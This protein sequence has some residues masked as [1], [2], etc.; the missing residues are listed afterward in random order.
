MKDYIV[1]DLETT[2]FS[3]ETCEIIEIGAWKVKEGVVVDK[4]CTL[5]RPLT[6]IPRDVQSIT[7]ITNE[8]VATCDTMEVILPEF[9]DFCEDLPFLGHNLPF[10][11]RFLEYRGKFIGV[12]FSL[13]GSRLGIDTLYLSKKLLPDL[14]VI[15]VP[16]PASKS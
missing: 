16:F 4:F 1:L 14:S 10:D 6:Y 5:V 15:Y 11:Y 9:F 7:G 8:M 13:K 3:P 2:G 12:D